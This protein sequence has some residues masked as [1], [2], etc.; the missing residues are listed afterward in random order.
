MRAPEISVVTCT[1]NP[2]PHYF[3]RLL[4]AL[5]AQ[6]LPTNQWELIVVDNRSD[7][8]VEGRFDF[9][10]HP[11]WRLVREESLGLTPARLTGIREASGEVLIFVDDDNVLDPDYLQEVTRIAAERPYLG[12]WSGQCRGVFEEPPPEWTRRYWGNLVIREFNEDVWSNLPRLAATMPCGA[13]LCLRRET[14]VRY[15]AVN[16]AGE[17]RVQFDRKGASLMSGG[18]ND[19]AACACDIGLGVG[20]ISTLK[21]QHLISPGRLTEDYLARLAHGI[22]YS[23]VLLDAERGIVRPPRSLA[24]RLAN[25]LRLWLVGGPHRTILKAAMA[26][27]DAA[28]RLLAARDR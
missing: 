21:L 7:P 8:P 27:E 16:D 6:T 25:R 22:H 1:H 13:G 20:L 15:L 5:R 24:G 28:I 3:Q 12:A 9:A 23:S 26:G 19:L 10:W 14:A 18:D 2:K 11:H 17:R 4:D